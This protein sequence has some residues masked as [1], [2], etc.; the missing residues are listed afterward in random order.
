METSTPLPFAKTPCVIAGIETQSGT[1][2]P[3]SVYDGFAAPY[4]FSGSMA[5]VISGY[6]QLDNPSY[7]TIG[8]HVCPPT[9]GVISFFGTFNGTE[10]API[11]LRQIGDDGYS[12]KTSINADIHGSHD[13]IGSIAAL[14]AIRFVL[15]T[16]GLGGVG[17]AAGRMT[18]SVSTL[19]GIEHEAPP[20]KFGNQPFHKGIYVN[21]TTGSGILLY[22]PP[23]GQR[24]VVTDLTLSV[25]SAGANITL[26]EDDGYANPD[27]WMYSTYVK[28]TSND[29]QIITCNYSTPF[30][31]SGLNNGLYL[32]VDATST[33]RGVVQ[34]Y[35]SS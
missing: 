3:Q 21:N 22:Q 35:Y 13:Y 9:S 19:E 29:T 25:L 17:M 4:D 18:V 7:S 12:Q 8:V 34:G 16:T 30:V 14:R 6:Y 26:Y 10:Y 15:T 2:R 28:T 11:T 20:H 33:V 24:F 23:T 1:F 5:N 31:A 27:A 32:A